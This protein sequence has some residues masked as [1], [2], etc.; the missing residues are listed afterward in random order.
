[1]SE[2]IPNREMFI[3]NNFLFQAAV[4]VSN[5]QLPQLGAYYN[6]CAKSIAKK[7]KLRVYP[8]CFLHL[9]PSSSDPLIKNTI[10]KKCDCALVLARTLPYRRTP[11]NDSS[12]SSER[13][14]HGG[15]PTKRGRGGKRRRRHCLS[16]G[17]NKLAVL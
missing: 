2:I 10:C 15:G 4:L 3:R 16:C 14:R 11:H 7:L 9:L 13:E 5:R 1:M 8:S 17:Y 6:R 12:S